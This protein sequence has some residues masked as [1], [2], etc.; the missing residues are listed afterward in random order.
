MIYF[1]T[2]C[3]SGFLFQMTKYVNNKYIKQIVNIAALIIPV[4]L[5]AFRGIDVG[6]D[7]SVYAYPVYKSAQTFDRFLDFIGYDGME[8]AFL[9][10]EYIGSKYIHSFAFVLGTIQFIIDFCFYK[11]IKKTYGEDSLAIN[12]MI[13]YFLIYGG[14]YNAIRQ[15]VAIALLLLATTYFADK[16]YIY[17]VLLSV[18]AVMFHTTALV[19]LLLFAI[20]AVADKDKVYKV[21]NFLIVAFSFVLNIYWESVF[22]TIFRYITIW[23]DNYSD[24][25][26]YVKVGER[27]ETSIIC[28]VIALVIIYYV[29][30][31]S[32]SRWN[33]LL[34]TITLI[35]IF[36]QPVG[37]KLHQASRL[38]LY[39]EAFL[40]MIF[41]LAHQIIHFRIG[42]KQAQW[43]INLFIFIF[44]FAIWFYSVMIH[45]SNSVLPYTF[46]N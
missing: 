42:Y 36:Y 43:I 23:G 45:N 44:F 12:M 32:E 11:V 17:T 2:F 7:T 34:I 6:K 10:L 16:K 37:E 25:L 35:Y 13:F 18:S 31:Q 26:I 20:Y 30:K 19:G 5:G 40:I 1:V 15:S 41:P 3:L 29:N 8:P 39:P 14:T 38:L 4:L 28:G 24:Y 46:L 9:L 33:K 27:N 22:S 21:I